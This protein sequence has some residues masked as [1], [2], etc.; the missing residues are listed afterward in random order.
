MFEPLVNQ[1]FKVIAIEMPGFGYSVK[2]SQVFKSCRSSANMN[3]NGPVDI[4]MQVLDQLN[5]D[6]FHLFGFSWGGGIAIS[7]T[8][9][10]K[11]RVESL[12]LHMASYTEVKN[13]LSDLETKTLIIWFKEDQIHPHKLGRYLASRMPNCK[14]MELSCGLFKSWKAFANYECYADL[15]LPSILEF[16]K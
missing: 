9:A 11:R 1:G 10:L 4:I 3:E 5:I 14:Y 15:F 2:Y 7:L 16:L 12:V 8:L 6:T 13:E